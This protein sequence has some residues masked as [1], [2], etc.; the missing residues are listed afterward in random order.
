MTNPFDPEGASFLALRNAQGQF[1]LWPSPVAT[2]AGWLIAYGP[3]SRRSCLEHI[4][5][6]WTD[7]RPLSLTE[8]MTRP[9]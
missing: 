8:A 9:R 1:S 7:M 6:H 5:R 3:A 4:D 2:P